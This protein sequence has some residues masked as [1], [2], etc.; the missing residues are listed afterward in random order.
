MKVYSYIRAGKI[1][2]VSLNQ[3]IRNLSTRVHTDSQSSRKTSQMRRS[4]HCQ[5]FCWV[6]L[7]ADACFFL[8]GVVP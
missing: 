4:I 1:Y 8:S 7:H 3:L 6:K 5:S 2:A